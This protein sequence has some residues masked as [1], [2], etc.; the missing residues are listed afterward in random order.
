[1]ATLAAIKLLAGGV[2]LD[3]H[4]AKSGRAIECLNVPSVTSLS[5]LGVT[6]TLLADMFPRAAGEESSNT[7]LR[8]G[9]PPP[10]PAMITTTVR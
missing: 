3:N 6:E 2:G 1:M 10:G 9:G 8:R 4:T 5:G 7:Y